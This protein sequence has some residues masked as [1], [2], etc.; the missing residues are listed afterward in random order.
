MSTSP[1]SANPAQDLPYWVGLSTFPKFG[2]KRFGLLQNYFPDMQAAYSAGISELKNAGID[3]GVAQE[4]SAHRQK[5]DLKEEME[6]LTRENITVITIQS[7]GYP[8]LLKEI[9]DAP[10]LLYCQGQL[11]E[12]I[13]FSLA[14]VGSRKFSSYGQQ[15]TQFLVSRLTQTGLVIISGLA[16]GIDALA[17]W[18]CLKAGGKTIAVLGSGV[19][20]ESIYPA[21][22]RNLAEKIIT[23]GGA[24]ISEFPYGTLA[25]SYHFP[26]RNRIISGL[27]LGTLIIEA[28]EDSGA[29]ITARSA[30][31]QNREVFAVPGSMFSANSVGANKLIQAGAKLVTSAE[32][33][34]ETF[35]LGNI[36]ELVQ[37]QKAVAST[38]AEEKLFAVISREPTHI[39]ELTRASQLDTATINATLLTMELKGYVRNLG[40]GN[41]VLS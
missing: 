3:E 16:L 40:G 18:E 39:N 28:A 30:L 21:A 6:K 13:N 37:A 32:E 2:P 33:I 9:Y 31:E 7:P 1:N 11:P 24:V 29:L 23:S 5:I 8:K 27:A 26:Q 15:A 36:K 10:P 20:N 12:G 14:V 38:P 22:N 4:F 25:L 19:N 34:L 41:Y 35:S 17:H